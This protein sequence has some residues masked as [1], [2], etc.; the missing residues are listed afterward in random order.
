MIFLDLDNVLICSSVAAGT[1]GCKE[2]VL[3]DGEQ[4]FVSLRDGSLSF[5]QRLRDIA[6]VKMLTSSVRDYALSMDAAFGFGF[7]PDEIIARED[8]LVSVQ[9]GY[10]ADFC[11]L[12]EGLSP[13]GV[14][15]D[16]MAPMDTHARLKR[17]ALGIDADRYFQIRRFDGECDPDVFFD[18]EKPSMLANIQFLLN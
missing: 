6:H 2:V 5:I 10:G 9:V 1:D 13:T 8:Y 3:P 12:Y 7:S 15:I 18:E 4:Y 16:D 11:L 14:L 17:A